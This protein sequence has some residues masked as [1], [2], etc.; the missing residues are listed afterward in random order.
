MAVAGEGHEPGVGPDGDQLP[1][2]QQLGSF[3]LETVAGAVQGA[4]QRFA[5]PQALFLRRDARKFAQ[6][7]LVDGGRLPSRLL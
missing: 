4:V 2:P 6:D 7:L 1:L 5:V 3:D